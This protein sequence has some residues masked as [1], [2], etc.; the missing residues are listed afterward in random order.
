M[1]HPKDTITI[2]W[3]NNVYELA[4]A[5]DMEIKEVIKILNDALLILV[6]DN[7]EEPLDVRGMYDSWLSNNK[8]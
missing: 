5:G 6:Q 2:S 1:E 4:Y 8:N 7:K 3:E